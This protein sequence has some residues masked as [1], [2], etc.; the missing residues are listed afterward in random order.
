M[1]G[2]QSTFQREGSIYLVCNDKMTKMLSSHLKNLND[3]HYDI[4][5]RCVKHS[6]FFWIIFIL[7]L[8]LSYTDK[9]LAFQ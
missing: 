4:A 7:D 2:F 9:L 5:K 8:A 1:I 3:T 6:S